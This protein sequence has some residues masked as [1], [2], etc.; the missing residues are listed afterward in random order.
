MQ[1]RKS[2]L[3]KQPGLVLKGFPFLIWPELIRELRAAQ[4]MPQI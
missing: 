2:L 3:E 1:D 4:L